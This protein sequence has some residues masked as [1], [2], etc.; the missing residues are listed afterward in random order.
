MEQTP[1]QQTE[2]IAAAGRAR[3]AVLAEEALQTPEP[4]FAAT[5]DEAHEL[6]AARQRELDRVAKAQALLDAELA[7]ET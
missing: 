4:D 2:A 1:E 6:E 7:G 5:Y 3:D